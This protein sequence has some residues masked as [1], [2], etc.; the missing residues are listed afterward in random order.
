MAYIQSSGRHVGTDQGALGGIAKFKKGV[1]PFL[2]LLLAVQ[3]QHGQVDVVEQLGVVLDAVAAREEDDDLLLEV[4]LEERKQQQ[5]TLVG[6]ADDVALLQAFNG[7]V[8]L[9][10]IDVDVQRTRPQGDTRQ[11]LDLGRLR[12]REQHRLPLVLGQDLDD[13]PHLILEANL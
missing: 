8:L 4:A 2:L 7:A 9:P 12:G 5:K 10:V 6:V 1:G 3:V 13:L 11:I